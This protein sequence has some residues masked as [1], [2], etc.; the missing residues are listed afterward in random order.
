MCQTAA[1]SLTIFGSSFASFGLCTVLKPHQAAGPI[2]SCS[3][4]TIPYGHVH[5]GSC[6]GI[7]RVK[8][9]GTV[10]MFSNQLQIKKLLK[11]TVVSQLLLQLVYTLSMSGIQISTYMRTEPDVLLTRQDHSL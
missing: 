10:P 1:E 5:G 2:L 4:Y 9:A 6:V 3:N 7:M 8:E 11:H